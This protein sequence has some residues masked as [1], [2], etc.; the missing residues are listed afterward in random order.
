[1]RLE[2]DS[3]QAPGEGQRD[4]DREAWFYGKG[5][6]PIGPHTPSEMRELFASGDLEARDLVWTE[7]ME[8]WAEARTLDFLRPGPPS[9]QPPAHE[10][11]D[12]PR[13]IETTDE[14][15]LAPP[16]RDFSPRAFLRAE[17]QKEGSQVRPWVRYFARMIDIT[18]GQT[19]IFMTSGNLDLLHNLPTMPKHVMYFLFG[20]V[21]I[22]TCLMSTWGTT[23]GKWLMKIQVTDAQ[24]RKLEMTQAFRRSLQV[25]I[26]G[27]GMGIPILS[28]ITL[29]MSHGRLVQDGSTRWDQ[30]G[31]LKVVH[32]RFT[33]R[34]IALAGL[35][36][37]FFFQVVVAPMVPAV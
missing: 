35:A 5:G 36:F 16:R 25:W 7:G 2:K 30:L 9:S 12:I 24:G 6:D 20:W 27:M 18:V 26:R 10:E 17:V 22:E 4:P 23:P 14:P 29:M 37:T 31:N 3:S 15:D 13:P 8:N 21:L 11:T 33:F 28:L 34:R 19:F 1:M 32:G